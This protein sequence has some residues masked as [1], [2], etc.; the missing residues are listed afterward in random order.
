MTRDRPKKIAGR[1]MADVQALA[2]KLALRTFPCA[3][4]T[5]QNKPPRV[6]VLP[7]NR[8]ARGRITFQP[9]GTISFSSSVH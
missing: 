3:W 7:G 9:S 8:R 5:Q 2:E 6:R 4:R 1:E